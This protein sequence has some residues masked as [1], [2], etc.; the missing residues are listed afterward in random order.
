MNNRIVIVVWVVTGLAL[1]AG[2]GSNVSVSPSPTEILPA[3]IDASK[4]ELLIFTPE[5]G[6][7]VYKMFEWIIKA[8]G[9]P[10]ELR[11]IE[12]LTTEMT[13]EGLKEGAFDMVFLQSEPDPEDEIDFYALAGIDVAI[14][15]HSDIGVD[16]VTLEELAAIFAG[17]ITNWAELG[18]ANQEIVP[19]VMPEFKPTTKRFRSVVL[20]DTPFGETA[21]ITPEER[22]GILSASGIAG[23]VSYAQWTTGIFLELDSTGIEGQQFKVLAIDGKN[24]NQPDYP[25]SI[26]VG[27]GFL[28]ERREELT[29][30]LNWLTEFKTTSDG[31][32]LLQVLDL[33][34]PGGE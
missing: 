34:V 27:F 7:A 24:V 23:G 2:C 31:I 12:G 16:N 13:L 3:A 6:N 25:I 15:V 4:P 19:F 10:C 33:S 11:I 21:H 26:L 17:D 30:F 32:R 8:N 5:G 29:P 28:P 14:Y 22:S 9:I 20:G 18:G 1:V